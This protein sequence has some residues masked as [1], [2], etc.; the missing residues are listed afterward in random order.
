MAGIQEREARGLNWGPREGLYFC[1]R[2]I[3]L[4]KG[5]CRA[6]CVTQEG[7]KYLS[8]HQMSKLMAEKKALSALFTLRKS[9]QQAR[10]LEMGEIRLEG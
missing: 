6:T 2:S 1:Q 3:Q 7:V 5:Q 4:R 8:P 9:P 10:P